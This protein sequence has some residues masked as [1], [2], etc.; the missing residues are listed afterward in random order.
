MKRRDDRSWQIPGGVLELDE[1]IEAGVVREVEEESGIVVRVHRL[2][3]VHKN[4]T[5]GVV[6][7]VYRCVPVGGREQVSDESTAVEWLTLEEARNRLNEMFWLR[8]ED[9]LSGEVRTRT[10]DGCRLIDDPIGPVDR[11]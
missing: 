2:S 11:G 6:S 9:A 5:R 1:S 7:L 10:H 4:L 3:A 8:V